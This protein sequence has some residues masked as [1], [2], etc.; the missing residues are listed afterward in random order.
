VLCSGVF[1]GVLGA[2]CCIRG[3]ALLCSALMYLQTPLERSLSINR[4]STNLLQRLSQPLYVSTSLRPYISLSLC[5][6]LIP[7][8]SFTFKISSNKSHDWTSGIGREAQKE[9]I[10]IMPDHLNTFFEHFFSLPL[11]SLLSWLLDLLSSPF[12]SLSIG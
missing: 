4:I 8:V 12:P 6:P 1:S 9:L 2:G 10:V 5:I 7:P 3:A 11:P